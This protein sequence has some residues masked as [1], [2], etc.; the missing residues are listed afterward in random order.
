M[1]HSL[2]LLEADIRSELDKLGQ[3]ESEFCEAEARLDFAADRLIPNYDRA[4][5]GY[6]LHGFYNGCETIFRTI[7][8]FF[9]NDL[10]AGSWHRDLLRR[11]LLEVRGFRPRVI[12]EELFR[13]LDDFRSFRH[14]FRHSYGFE[15]DWERERLVALKFRKALA[16]VR[17]QVDEFLRSLGE[18]ESE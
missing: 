17:T 2:E 9:E 1:R 12:D 16:L 13:L 18:L 10:D 8:R 11:M 6:L 3:L 7:A 5:V 14:K 15:L 4:A